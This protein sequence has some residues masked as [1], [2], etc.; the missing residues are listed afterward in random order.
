MRGKRSLIARLGTRALGRNGPGLLFETRPCTG[1][2]GGGETRRQRRRESRPSPGAEGPIDKACEGREP[3]GQLVG[4]CARNLIAHQPTRT[5]R[6]EH[7]ESVL[8][9]TAVT[10]VG[11][12]RP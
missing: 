12:L 7:T 2:S 8:Q 3:L 4:G 1:D 9:P 10:C 11:M 6:V 5:R